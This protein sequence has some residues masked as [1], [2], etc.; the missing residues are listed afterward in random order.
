MHRT[1]GCIHVHRMEPATDDRF[2]VK[3]HKIYLD[4][5][6]KETFEP[7]AKPSTA[8]VEAVDLLRT[9]KVGRDGAL[10]AAATKSLDEQNWTWER[11]TV[12]GADTQPPPPVLPFSPDTVWG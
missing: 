8:R 9:V 10:N 1:E 4:G 3:W 5:E 7:T 12:D 6:G 11:S 2:R